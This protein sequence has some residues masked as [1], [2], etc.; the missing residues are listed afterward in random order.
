M[1]TAENLSPTLWG[2]SEEG[3]TIFILEIEVELELLC[4]QTLKNMIIFPRPKSGDM[5]SQGF[6]F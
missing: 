3:K 5:I 6:F 2:G 4:K 1:D